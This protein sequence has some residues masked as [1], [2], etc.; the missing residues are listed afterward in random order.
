MSSN[1]CEALES[2]TNEMLSCNQWMSRGK[3]SNVDRSCEILASLFNA[4]IIAY[5][6]HK[7]HEDNCGYRYG[8]C[9]GCRMTI[10]EKDLPEHENTCG[11]IEWTCPD[12]HFKCTK[13]EA[14]SH[15]DKI[16][17]QKQLSQ[18]E[19]KMMIR[20]QEQETINRHLQQQLG[21]LSRK[22]IPSQALFII[23]FV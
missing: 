1:T 10:L 9:R 14:P 13:N 8:Q 17:F 21:R 23:Y 7:K 3:I 6:A 5:E 16:C 22:E 12:C 2:L 4:Q 18:R 11:L 15:T 19:A 20:F